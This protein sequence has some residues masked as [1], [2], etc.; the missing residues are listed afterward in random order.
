M[1][2]RLAGRLA[3]KSP[4]SL[5]VDVHG[6]GY[7]V[8]ISLNAFAALSEEGGAVEL[9][10]HTHLRENALELF[11]FVDPQ[12]KAL[13]TALLAVSGVGPRMAMNILSGMPTRDLMQALEAGDVARLVTIPGVGK[14]TAERLVV[15]LRDRVARLRIARAHDEGPRPDRAATEATSAL[16]NL[17]Y[18][19]PEAE[20]AVRWAMEQGEDDLAVLI[21]R[22]LQRL[23][24]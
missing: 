11:G 5:L 4:D 2:G 22:A 19:Q 17:G 14:K 7:H 8:W 15:E 12:E 13:F 1:I 6:V 18:R 9:A 3:H 23:S 10:I 21:R 16:V 24:S 20:R